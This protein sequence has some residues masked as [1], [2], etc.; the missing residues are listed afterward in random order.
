LRSAPEHAYEQLVGKEATPASARAALDGVRP[1]Q[2]LAVPI[3]DGDDARALLAGLWL[4]HGALHEA[5]QIIQDLASPTA[6]F[7][8]AILHRL[9]GDFGNARYW[10]A[11]CRDHRAMRMLGAVVD[12]LAGE[13]AAGNDP[14]VAHVV[15]DG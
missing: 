10:Y 13:G 8:H 9:E 2:L 5:H 12:S 11:R 4:W 7:W 3:V 1:E 15:A 6:S 14:L